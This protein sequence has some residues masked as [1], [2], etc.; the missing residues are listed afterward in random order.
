MAR[1]NIVRVPKNVVRIAC[2]HVLHSAVSTTAIKFWYGKIKL[3]SFLVSILRN[4]RM[5][6]MQHV[7]FKH[8]GGKVFG[9]YLLI[10]RGRLNWDM[11][12]M[13]NRGQ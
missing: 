4:H 8:G 1:I 6:R 5:V 3:I 12:N 9:E 10:K 11:I 13:I 2:L 7:L